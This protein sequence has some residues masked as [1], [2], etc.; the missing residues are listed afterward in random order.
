MLKRRL[1]DVAAQFS[2]QSKYS[3]PA[4]GAFFVISV[5]LFTLLGPKP[6][7]LS[8]DGFIMI[9]IL[10]IAA[11]LWITEIIPLSA[12]G[13][14]V[15]I[16]QPIMRV[17]TAEE[18]FATFGNTAVFF[19]LGAFILSAAVEKHQLHKRIALKI[20]SL[21]KGGPKRF[22]AGLTIT[23]AVMSFAIPSHAV[24]ALLLPVII[25]ILTSLNLKPK[26]SNFGKAV[27]LSVIAG[28]N[29]GSWGTLL[30]G[31]RNPLTISFLSETIGHDI[32]FLGWMK[33]TVPVVALSLPFMIIILLIL[34]PPEINDLSSA[35][36][37]IEE[38]VEELGKMGI[39]EKKTILI[40]T[41]TLILLIGFSD[42]LG[43]AVTVILGALSLF[44]LRVINWDDVE[45]RVQ[46]GI[47]FLYGGAITMGS[48]LQQTGA[49]TWVTEKI[50]PLMV[51]EYVAF[52]I[53]ILI[54]MLLTQAMSNTAAVA[55]LLPIGYSISTQFAGISPV[56]LSIGLALSGGGAFMLVIST[57]AAAI[58]YSSGYFSTKDLL[59]YG[60]VAVVTNLII[61]YIISQ[62][63][64]QMII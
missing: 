6:S 39:Q 27:A 12:T 4:L 60:S 30:G 63:Y 15:I 13:I 36:K 35:R 20:L 45:D 17:L 49:A 18:A 48:G 29:I 16:L 59:K 25:H 43:V 14:L 10:L 58:S 44:F 62:T 38:E 31:A 19:L 28:T 21:F 57:P 46:W 47:L 42:F 26:Q 24:A 1:K 23:G 50:T 2:F 5:L 56:I 8:R 3:K 54:G 55:L 40:Y 32:S 11:F 9:G 22:I 41:I 61:I 37:E 34:F 51:N 33:F 53:L 64:W 52:F 7:D